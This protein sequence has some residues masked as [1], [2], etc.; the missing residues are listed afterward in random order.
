MNGH[1]FSVRYV[2]EV[3]DVAYRCKRCGIGQHWDGA[4][5]QCVAWGAHDLDPERMDVLIPSGAGSHGRGQLWRDDVGGWWLSTGGADVRCNVL[6]SQEHNNQR[7]LA[8]RVEGRK[9]KVRAVRKWR[10]E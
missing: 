3:G 7:W 4:R 9:V 10:G 1:V 5:Q 2:T 6:S 8:L